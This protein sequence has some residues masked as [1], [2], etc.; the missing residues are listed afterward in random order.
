MSTVVK[1]FAVIYALVFL[2][3]LFLAVTSLM[4][5]HENTLMNPAL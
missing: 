5:M 2:Y 1:I 4:G 3:I